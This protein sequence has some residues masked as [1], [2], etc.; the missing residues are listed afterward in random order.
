MAKN[1]GKAKVGKEGNFVFQ[2]LGSFL[3]LLCKTAQGDIASIIRD[4]VI[5]FAISNALPNG[6]DGGS[7]SVTKFN[8]PMLKHF[9]FVALVFWRP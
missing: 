2:G 4:H 1:I 5:S 6:E 7:V 9:L 8:D 3:I